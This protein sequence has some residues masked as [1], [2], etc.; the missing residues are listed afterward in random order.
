M[1]V[2]SAENRVVLIAKRDVLAGE[3]LT[4]DYLFETD[5]SEDEKVPCLC[6][7]PE[8]RKFMN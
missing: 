2:G 6:G 7:T 5:E 4:Y 8:C 1:S 3:E